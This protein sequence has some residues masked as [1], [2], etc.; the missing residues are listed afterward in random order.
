MKEQLLQYIETVEKLGGLGSGNIGH[1]GRPGEVGGS[2][3][4]DEV[5]LSDKIFDS[6]TTN[7]SDYDNLF[8]TRGEQKDNVKGITQKEYYEKYKGMVGKV[9][10][11]SP[12]QYLSKINYQP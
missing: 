10:K 12:D 11:M 5:G 9:V 3:P 8:G 7:I 1:S 2:S 6:N 4:K